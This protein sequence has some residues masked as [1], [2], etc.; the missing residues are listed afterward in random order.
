MR[1]LISVGTAAALLSAFAVATAMA[2][3]PSPSGMVKLSV[4]QGA[5]TYGQKTVRRSPG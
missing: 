3:A 5:R 2:G 1:M 4:A